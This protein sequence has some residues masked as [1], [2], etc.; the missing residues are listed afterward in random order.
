MIPAAP[1]QLEE[2]L[3]ERRRALAGVS[4]GDEAPDVLFQRAT[5][6]ARHGLAQITYRSESGYR[7]KSAMR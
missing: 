3:L 7:G 4:L 6:V 1:A 5:L 2:N